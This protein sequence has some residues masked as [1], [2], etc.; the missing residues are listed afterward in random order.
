MILN[1]LMRART[2]IIKTSLDSKWILNEKSGKLLRSEFDGLSYWDLKFWWNLAKAICLHR[3]DNLAK[4]GVWSFK[5]GIPLLGLDGSN[6][7]S[8]RFP[9]V[10][11][12][13]N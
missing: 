2:F 8:I 12:E 7:I 11:L 3:D 9:L 6:W 5:L 10:W 4:K 1:D 13:F